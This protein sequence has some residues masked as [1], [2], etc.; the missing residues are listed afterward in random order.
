M[1]DEQIRQAIL[2][3]AGSD[4][5]AEE[6]LDDIEAEM[7]D[8]KLKAQVRP[9]PSLPWVHLIEHGCAVWLVDGVLMEAPEL[10]YR[11]GIHRFDWEQATE[12]TAPNTQEYLD[13][14]NAALGTSFKMSQFAGR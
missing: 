11:S 4:D 8:R 9:A 12:V 7:T 1:T 3:W 10:A 6:L 2:D 13:A 14:V 5:G